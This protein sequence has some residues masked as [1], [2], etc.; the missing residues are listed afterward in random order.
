MTTNQTN[1]TYQYRF[2]ISYLLN[3]QVSQTTASITNFQFPTT[4]A[5]LP[6]SIV[7]QLNDTFHTCNTT[8]TIPGMYNS[9]I[10]LITS[11]STFKPT[12]IFF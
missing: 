5:S 12:P 2:T 6:L 1:I 4:N 9:L 10:R 7:R 11:G 3:R 8:T